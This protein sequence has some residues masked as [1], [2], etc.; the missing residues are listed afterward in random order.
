[1]F[2][3]LRVTDNVRESQ[4]STSLY[5]EPADGLPVADYQPGQYITLRLP[6]PLAETFG[7]DILIC[8]ARPEYDLILDL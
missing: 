1:M 8:C 3:L 4:A 6:A 5:L 2:C 7:G